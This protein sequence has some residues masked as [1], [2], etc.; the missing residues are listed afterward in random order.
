MP[1]AGFVINVDPTDPVSALEALGSMEGVEIHGYDEKGN[2]VAVLESDTTDEMEALVRQ[3]NSIDGILS[4]G[5]TY[6]N[7]EDEVEKVERGEYVPSC[8]L[9]NKQSYWYES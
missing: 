4:V 3:V 7:A 2:V 9:G 8:S 6:F 5:L 1:I